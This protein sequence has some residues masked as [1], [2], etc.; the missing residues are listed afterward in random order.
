MQRA[1]G[2]AMRSTRVKDA[3]LRCNVSG[4]ENDW[5]MGIQMKRGGEIVFKKGL[6]RWSEKFVAISFRDV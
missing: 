2:R 6:S 5:L 3:R 4:R 1:R